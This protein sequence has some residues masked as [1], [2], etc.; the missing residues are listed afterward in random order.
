MCEKLSPF[1][2]DE[3]SK[4]RTFLQSTATPAWPS[5]SNNQ[6]TKRKP[7]LLE[8]AP[9][10]ADADAEGRGRYKTEQRLIWAR[11]RCF[12]VCTSATAFIIIFMYRLSPGLISQYS[13]LN[14]N[15]LAMTNT[16]NP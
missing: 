12:T 16:V 9:V 6:E 3:G 11:S 1:S 10:R 2:E 15:F 8:H 7:L 5:T 13:L 14:F 4:R